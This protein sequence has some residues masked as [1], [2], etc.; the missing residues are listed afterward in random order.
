[1]SGLGTKRG[2]RDQEKAFSERK[3]MAGAQPD[4]GRGYRRLGGGNRERQSV[5]AGSLCESKTEQKVQYVR[6][7]GEHGGWSDQR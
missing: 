2:K 5:F 3:Q 4:R 7:R 6:T 1:M